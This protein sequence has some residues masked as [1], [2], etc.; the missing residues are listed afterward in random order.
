MTIMMPLC[1][2]LRQSVDSQKVFEE[3]IAERNFKKKNLI[4]T[5][6]FRAYDST[7]LIDYTL[8]WAAGTVRHIN[9]CRN[10][11]VQRARLKRKI[12]ELETKFQN[13]TVQRCSFTCLAETR[14]E[15]GDY[16]EIPIRS[17]S[18]DKVI[19]V[20]MYRWRNWIPLSRQARDEKSDRMEIHF[21][22]SF[23]W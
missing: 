15:P 14:R 2:L 19:G 5:Q 9:P 22:L 12:I 17:D 1:V 21:G 16:L 23:H 11:V 10:W 18:S 7:L 13:F 8:P 6:R 4:T 20:T 3:D